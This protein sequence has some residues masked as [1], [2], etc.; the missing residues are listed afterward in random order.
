MTKPR[1]FS[2]S[3]FAAAAA[4][5]VAACATPPP[6]LDLA[7]T[8][9]SA[10]GKYLVALQPPATPPAINKIHAWTIQLKTPDGAPVHHARIDVD[11]GCRST[12]TAC[13]HNRA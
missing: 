10:Q 11:G 13:R 1:F 12:A 9:T 3:S 5:L 7:T 2:A 8:R 6:E 4:M